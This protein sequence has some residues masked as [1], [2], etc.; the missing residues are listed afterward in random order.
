[1][2]T[3]YTCYPVGSSEDRRYITARVTKEVEDHSSLV[4]KAETPKAE[5][6]VIEKPSE[7]PIE[8][9]IPTPQPVQEPTPQPEP[10]QDV[11]IQQPV[12]EPTPQEPIQEDVLTPIEQPPTQQ[13]P[14]EPINED[15]Q[16]SFPVDTLIAEQNV[17]QEHGA[18]EIVDTSAP[19][20]AQP[21]TASTSDTPTN[22]ITQNSLQPTMIEKTDVAPILT[23]EQQARMRKAYII[24][25]IL[26][27]KKM[28]TQKLHAFGRQ[29]RIKKTTEMFSFLPFLKTS[30]VQKPSVSRLSLTT[31]I[32]QAIQAKRLATASP[33]K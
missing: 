33:N 15:P 2:I 24:S 1:M 25:G 13:V 9:P 14:Q 3:A 10:V 7:K 30:V 27:Y 29:Q 20:Q 4:K 11:Q 21:Q 19:Q 28:V 16:E 26:L 5:Q 31:T 17:P 22:N 8:E 23:Y 18:A 12:A 6:Q 32:K